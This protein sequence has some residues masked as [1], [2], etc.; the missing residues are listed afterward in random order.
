MY[1]AG[2]SSS[3]TALSVSS[4]IS[5]G[6]VGLPGTDAS[7]LVSK[8]SDHA[9]T[10]YEFSA[11]TRNE[12]ATPGSRALAMYCGTAAD[13]VRLTTAP[14]TSRPKR[15]IGSPL[16]YGACHITWIDVLR[17]RPSRGGSTSKGGYGLSGGARVV[18]TAAAA[19]PDEPLSLNASTD[20]V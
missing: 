8:G 4:T 19:S 20:T 15:V 6:P 2:C 12:Y 9:P 5:G 7:V 14:S 1:S 18:A 16:S 13:A 11:R 10:P 17:A 3:V